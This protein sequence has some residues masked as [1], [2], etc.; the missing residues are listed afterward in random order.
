LGKKAERRLMA[1]FRLKEMAEHWFKELIPAFLV[2]AFSIIFS[3]YLG[4]HSASGIWKIVYRIFLRFF[5]YAL[6]LC[7]PLYLLRPIYKFILE[8]GKGALIQLGHPEAI[9]LH[10]LK[11]WLFRPFQGIGIGFLF[12][13]KLLVLI[14]VVSG[15]ASDASWPI[16][17]GR[18]QLGR[19]LLVTGITIFI[20][21][22]LSILWTLDDMGIRYHN[23]RDQELKM[24]GKYVG[25]I[26]P[27]IFGLY[28]LFSLLAQYPKESALVQVFRIILALYPPLVVLAVVHTHFITGR[29]DF[30]SK[31]NLLKKGGIWRD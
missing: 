4:D 9:T 22:V 16:I 24:I 10:P 18:F 29:M 13:T 21:L 14:Q 31:K 8:K 5:R 2:F 17:P 25:T 12:A 23:R 27:L 26:M 3:L 30:H 28:G 6:F 7:L 1:Q 19:L 15:P 20:S 11:H